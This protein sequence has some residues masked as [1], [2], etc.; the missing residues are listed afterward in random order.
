MNVK[1]K[2][3][4]TNYGAAR[5]IWIELRDIRDQLRKLLV[6]VNHALAA[7]DELMKQPG[8]YSSHDDE[9]RME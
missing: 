9:E 5:S 6:Q 7:Q 1:S 2:Q 3:I 4:R 8:V